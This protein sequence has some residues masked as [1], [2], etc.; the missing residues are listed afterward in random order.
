MTIILP[1]NNFPNLTIFYVDIFN[2]LYAFSFLT[3][4]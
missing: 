2:F 1:N 3:L 4:L